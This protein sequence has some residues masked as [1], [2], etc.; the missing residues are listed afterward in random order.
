V[1]TV[2]QV[3]AYQQALQTGGFLPEE[4]SAARALGFSD[5]EIE[6]I[7]QEIVAADPEDVT[8]S[9]VEY[10]QNL[11]QAYRE[12]GNELLGSANYGSASGSPVRRSE[13]GNQLVRVYETSTDFQLGNPTASTANIE[14]RVRRLDLPPDWMVDVSP[15][16]ATLAAGAVTTATITVS[17]GAPAVQG[18]RP[19]VAV[20]AFIGSELIGG[21]A[22]DVMIPRASVFDPRTHTRRWELYR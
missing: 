10:T 21:I 12:L 3:R 9:R 2:A 18:T 15:T 16:S 19:R 8:L 22:L 5:A 20:E 4:I 6:Q 13:D 11:I 1:L 17:A 7:R 14:L